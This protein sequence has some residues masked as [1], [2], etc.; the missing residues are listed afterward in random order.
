VYLELRE[1]S[2]KLKQQGINCLLPQ[3]HGGFLCL[4][5]CAMCL[6]KKTINKKKQTLQLHPLYILHVTTLLHA[7]L[8]SN[9]KS[10]TKN[11]KP[12]TKMKKAKSKRQNA[13]S[14]S[15]RL[16]MRLAR[17]TVFC[18]CFLIGDGLCT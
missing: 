14:K 15:K 16:K 17:V 2:V 3:L 10:K 7:Q 9:N 12:K 1:I 18:A 11:R 8:A 6:K 4:S 5:Q 13:K